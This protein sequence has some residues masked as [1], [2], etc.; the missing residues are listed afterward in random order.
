MLHIIKRDNY[1]SQRKGIKIHFFVEVR[2]RQLKQYQM[3]L[4]SH[5]SWINIS[6]LLNCIERLL[7]C[8]FEIFVSNCVGMLNNASL[9][10]WLHMYDLV[11]SVINEKLVGTSLSKWVR[12]SYITLFSFWNVSIDIKKKEAINVF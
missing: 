1:I 10:L 12:P 9:Q 2:R 4:F 11:R 8:V 6:V 5:L 7:Y 3:S